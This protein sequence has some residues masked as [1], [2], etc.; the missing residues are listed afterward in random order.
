MKMRSRKRDST[1]HRTTEGSSVRENLMRPATRCV[2]VVFS[3]PCLMC[4]G[5]TLIMNVWIRSKQLIVESTSVS[6]LSLCSFCGAS[7]VKYLFCY[8]I[9]HTPFLLNCMKYPTSFDSNY[10]SPARV[11]CTNG[12]LRVIYAI[13]Q[14][15]YQH[16]IV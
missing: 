7:Y 15:H 11:L 5:H 3:C 10:V 2:K 16:D 13:I 14:L 4:D 8:Y 6:C 12:L 1:E 9:E